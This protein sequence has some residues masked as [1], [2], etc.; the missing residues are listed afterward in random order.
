MK[1]YI[2]IISFLATFAILFC[3]I[4]DV[5]ADIEYSHGS[6]SN[7]SQCNIS[8]TN[9]SHNQSYKP[10]DSINFSYAMDCPKHLLDWPNWRTGIVYYP[11][12]CQ[13]SFAFAVP[14]PPSVNKDILSVINM[15]ETSFTDLGGYVRCS[16]NEV[17]EVPPEAVGATLAHIYV[18]WDDYQDPVFYWRSLNLGTIYEHIT[19]TSPP[20][21]LPWGG[22]IASG[23]SVTAYAASSVPCGSS[24]ASQTRTCSNGS[25]SGSYTNSS[26]SVVACPC[27]LPWGGS[28][29]SGASVTAYADS[30][31]PCGSTCSS[32]TRTCSNGTLG[33]SYTNSSCSIGVCCFC[34]ADYY[35]VPDYSTTECIGARGVCS[36]NCKRVTTGSCPDSGIF[37]PTKTTSEWNVFINNLP[38][39]ASVTSCN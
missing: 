5:G 6:Y 29:A 22:S 28:I 32:Q 38:S 7:L 30:S 9:I 36:S 31:V 34:S 16:S 26:C 8:I 35:Y 18:M 24:C 14:L 11:H 12:G 25:L 3:P 27:S 13:T 19:V 15:H 21:S 23:A 39:C 17:F 1:K 20:C 4:Q 2:L 10:G 37:V 33:G